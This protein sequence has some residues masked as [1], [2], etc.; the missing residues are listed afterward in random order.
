MEGLYLIYCSA[1]VIE[2]DIAKIFWNKK[3]KFLFSRWGSEVLKNTWSW[4][5]VFILSEIKR[6]YGQLY[7]SYSSECN[8]STAVL[9]SST[10]LISIWEYTAGQSN[11]KK[12]GTMKNSDPLCELFWESWYSQLFYLFN[13]SSKI[14]EWMNVSTI[15]N[16]WTKFALWTF[17]VKCRPVVMEQR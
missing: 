15:L 16:W 2:S 3:Q 17:S 7:F 12:L 6:Y 4:P 13:S 14:V 5:T 8:K 10:F 11:K 1:G 9:F